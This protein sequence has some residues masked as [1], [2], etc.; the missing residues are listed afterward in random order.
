MEFQ[1]GLFWFI[2]N[3]QKLGKV[4][5]GLIFHF[6]LANGFGTDISFF[7]FLQTPYKILQAPFSNA[8][9]EQTRKKVYDC[10]RLI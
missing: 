4:S 9:Q 6:Y 2:C 3:T 7:I 8:K 5:K 1:L 10:L